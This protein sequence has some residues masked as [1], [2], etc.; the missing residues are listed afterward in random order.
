MISTLEITR[1]LTKPRQILHILKLEYLSTF[2]YNIFIPNSNYLNK[3]CKNVNNLP[4]GTIW[5]MQG[6]ICLPIALSAQHAN[7]P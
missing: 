3:N 7:V 1:S 4:A 2:Q 6:S 5:N